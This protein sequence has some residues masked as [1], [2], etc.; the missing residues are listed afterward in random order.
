MKTFVDNNA[1]ESKL[2]GETYNDDDEDSGVSNSNM[3]VCTYFTLQL[4]YSLFIE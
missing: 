2:Q 4:L 3:R 1:K